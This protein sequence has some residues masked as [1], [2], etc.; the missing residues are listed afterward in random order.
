MSPAT[1]SPAPIALQAICL[2][3]VP[4]PGSPPLELEGLRAWAQDKLAKYQLP[5]RLVVLEALP[6][7]AMGKV[8]KKDLRKLVPPA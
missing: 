8:N 5:S 4:K 7:N 6:R 1:P 3:A 2:L